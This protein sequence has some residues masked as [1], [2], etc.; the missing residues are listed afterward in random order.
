M[1]RLSKQLDS[2]HSFSFA[3]PG[4]GGESSGS[5]FC[6]TVCS[7][8][9]PLTWDKLVHFYRQRRPVKTL[10]IINNLPFCGLH[11]KFT[12][13]YGHK[14]HGNVFLAVLLVPDRI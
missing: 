7:A 13:T 6:E 11:Q 1:N 2:S 8:Q 10:E 14:S 5:L 4:G 3:E 12:Y 9:L